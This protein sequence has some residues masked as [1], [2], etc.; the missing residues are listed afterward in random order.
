MYE[1]KAQL[2]IKNPIDR[3]LINSSMLPSLRRNP[4]GSLTLLIQHRSPSILPPGKGTWRPPGL[5]QAS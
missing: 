1:G 4:D 3:Y 2:L 5:V